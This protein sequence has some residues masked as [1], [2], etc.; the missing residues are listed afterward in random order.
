MTGS[1]ASK[2]TKL[3]IIMEKLTIILV[4]AMSKDSILERLSNSI[5]AYK[6]NPTD[7]N[8]RTVAFNGALIGLKHTLLKEGVESVIKNY[9]TLTAG[10]N[11]LNFSEQ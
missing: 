10:I 5:D 4:N 2:Q 11:L 3:I 6:N 8:F 7:D 9:D 1:N